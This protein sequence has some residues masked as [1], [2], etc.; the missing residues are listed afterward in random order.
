M[1]HAEAAVA[2]RITVAI[3]AYNAARYLPRAIQSVLDQDFQDFELIVVDDGSTD[4]T[5]SVARRHAGDPRL[6]IHR[7]ASNHGVAAALNSALRVARGYVLLHLDADDWLDVGALSV[8]LQRIEGPDRPAAVY[9]R[10]MLHFEGQ[11]PRTM[12]LCHAAKP[13]DHLTQALAPQ[14][15][16]A[17]RT[18]VLQ[19]LGGWT[20]HD[21]FEG[22]FFE[23]RWMLWRIAA[24]HPVVAVDQTLYHVCVR[25][26]SSSRHYRLSAS[27]AKFSLLC[28]AAADIGLEPVPTF[29]G[30]FLTARFEPLPDDERT[31]WSLI[32]VYSGEPDQALKRCLLAWH[33]SDMA[34]R[35]AEFL[36]IDASAEG[37]GRQLGEEMNLTYVPARRATIT[38]AFNIGASQA[39]HKYLMFSSSLDIV[40]RR[41]LGFHERHHRSIGRA[42]VAARLLGRLT[43]PRSSTHRPA[44][45]TKRLRDLAEHAVIPPYA[46]PGPLNIGREPSLPQQNPRTPS[47][48]DRATRMGFV[49]SGKRI[50]ARVVESCRAIWNDTPGPANVLCSDGLSI[51]REEFLALGGFDTRLPPSLTGADLAA[52]AVARGLRVSL[53]PAAEPF[54]Q[55][56]GCPIRWHD[57]AIPNTTWLRSG[58]SQLPADS[59]SPL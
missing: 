23:D 56:L 22:R 17:Y 45:L 54:F 41:V 34:T 59:P 50:D 16:R 33:Q 25:T 32:S 47:E 51:L 18:S 57:Y 55:L 29:Q 7:H 5:L 28:D 53:C 20:R 37:R 14:V 52:R 1:R 24:R 36:L 42:I 11:P 21:V 15:P 38:E 44:P 49:G 40:P 39:R 35:Q 10:A 9:G 6:R 48:W 2:P 8:V 43:V 31:E 58:P 27:L 30:G 26:E 3:P 4:E 13:L 12:A 46:A 19:E